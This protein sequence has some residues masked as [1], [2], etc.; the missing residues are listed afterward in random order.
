MTRVACIGAGAWGRNLVRNFHDLR[1]QAA[2][3]DASPATIQE[4]LTDEGRRRM[5][6]AESLSRASNMAI[7]VRNS[8]CRTQ[9]THDAA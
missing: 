3:C 2:V 1:A 8:Q 6:D 4:I 7:A 9:R 5:T